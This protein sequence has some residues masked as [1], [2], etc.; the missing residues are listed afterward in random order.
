[1]APAVT[2]VSLGNSLYLC[3]INP[4][5]QGEEETPEI[6]PGQHSVLAELSYT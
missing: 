4:D 1:M 5:S 3:T 2:L 6:K